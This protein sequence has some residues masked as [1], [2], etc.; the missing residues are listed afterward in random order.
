MGG[1]VGSVLPGSTINYEAP[2]GQMVQ[3]V[4]TAYTSSI[5]ETDDNPWETAS[6]TKPGPGTVAC[7]DR[8]PFGTVIE[9]EGRRFTCEDRMNK[10]YRESDHYDVWVESKEIALNWGKKELEIIVHQ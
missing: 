1:V 5:E 9:I 2:K 4:V 7:P 3:A 10:R 6:G 8:L